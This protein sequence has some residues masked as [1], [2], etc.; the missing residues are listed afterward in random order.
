MVPE[1]TKIFMSSQRETD[2]GLRCSPRNPNPYVNEVYRF[3]HNPLIRWLGFLG[4]HRRPMIGYF[5]FIIGSKNRRLYN[6][7]SIISVITL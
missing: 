6:T 4:L 1:T 5:S 3:R 2:I 7:M